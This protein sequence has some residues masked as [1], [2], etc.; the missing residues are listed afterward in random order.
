MNL[1]IQSCDMLKRV[2]VSSGRTVIFSIA[3]ILT[4]TTP[5]T[6]LSQDPGIRDT[7]RI[8][9]DSLIVGQSRPI[10]ITLVNDEA[11]ST[12][13]LGFIYSAVGGGYAKFDS[14]VY[15]NRMADPSVLDLRFVV[16]RDKDGVSPDSLVF[17][18]FYVAG[19]PL[20]TGNS[21]IFQV[22]MTGLS[23]GTFTLDTGKSSGGENIMILPLPVT[24]HFTP[25]FVITSVPVVVGTSAPTI[26]IGNPSQQD[27]AGSSFIFEITA[28]SPMNYPVNVDF[29]GMFNY[30]NENSVPT[31]FPILTHDSSE[32]VYE[33]SWQSTSSDIGIWR[34]EIEV[35]DSL[36][37]CSTEK[38]VVQVV[39]NSSYLVEMGPIESPVFDFPNSL[40]QGNFDDDIEP[41]ITS[42]GLG[43][44][45]S[46]WLSLYDRD[47]AGK[48]TVAYSP[49]G[50]QYLPY[51]GQQI[52][53][54]N[55]DENLDIL[56]YGG[57]LDS[58]EIMAFLGD[59]QNGFQLKSSTFNVSGW[60][61]TATIGNFN[62]DAYID[63]AVGGF[64]NVTFYKGSS[65]SQFT[66]LSQL[67][68]GDS[69]IS[70]ISTDFNVDG[71]DDIAVGTRQGLKIFIGNGLGG[72]TLKSTYS[73]TYG[74][75]DLDVTNDGSDFNNDN[76]FDL[77]IATPSIGN[78]SSQLMVY[79]GNGDGT[80]LQRVARTVK[81]QIIASSP[82][83][84]NGDGLL[85]I[86]YL[87]SGQKYVSIIFGDGDGFF[88]NE[89]RYS[90]ARFNPRK[91]IGL[92]AD[93]D[94]DMDIAVFSYNITAGSSLFLFENQSN[95]DGFSV[96][97]VDISGEDN[98]Q[99]EL[100]SAS[101]KILNRN[102]NTI[103]SSEYYR[104][105]INLN[106]QLDDYAT[107]NLVESGNYLLTVKP[108]PSQPVGTPFTVDFTVD[109]K[110]YRL[111]KDAVM[112]NDKYEFGVKFSGGESV[113]PRPGNFI[114]INPPLF[115]WP[116]ESDV[117]FQLAAD[118]DLYSILIDTT[119]ATAIFQPA[120]ALAVSDTTTYYWR[121]KPSGTGDFSPI[122]AFNL[123]PASP[124][125]GD[126]DGIAGNINFLD[127]VF[128]IDNFFRGGADSPNF[129]AADLNNDRAM[130]ILDLTLLVDY[131]FRS[132]QPP[133]CG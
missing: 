46:S 87:N 38:I 47:I 86:S 56:H 121:I 130:N 18:F 50:I 39:D 114:Y 118:L 35:C 69:V 122:Y 58:R 72:F 13:S 48:Y 99:F 1:N 74:S 11:I 3:V 125:C 92:D 120:A 25:K 32:D 45:G 127:L 116:S 59:G 71:R 79:L 14:V 93:V 37:I 4:L 33:F 26:S 113:V 100:L 91:M 109:N 63:Y 5:N 31:N 2:R 28:T 51:C 7:V 75:L 112:T 49:A 64:G 16:P 60:G 55:S 80:F 128:M 61:I 77:C 19:S 53:F 89:L 23:E 78:I 21:A 132:G 9:G 17:G 41:E 52:G 82:A 57:V 94:G 101:G 96:S 88:R 54:I 106:E 6:A 102:A 85:D 104:R 66:V 119:I 117:D 95:P 90:V 12:V 111:A 105:N 20:N 133:V 129:E 62:S 124:A 123:I 98:A 115:T 68:V 83:D 43:S 10:T 27:I 103:P 29:N 15:L 34:A 131:L 84:F 40:N 76:L 110:A 44:L 42:T 65:N 73:Q 8:E 36:G 107:L 67:A 97:S 24:D 126:V 30:D 108:D 81:G 70:L 22:F